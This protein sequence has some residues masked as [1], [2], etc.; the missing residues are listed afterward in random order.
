ML[1]KDEPSRNRNSANPGN[2]G[3]AAGNQ[4]DFPGLSTNPD[5]YPS[6][7]SDNYPALVSQRVATSLVTPSRHGATDISP[8]SA[9]WSPFGVKNEKGQEAVSST[10]SL[11]FSDTVTPGN[12]AYASGLSHYSQQVSPKAAIP[13][14]AA[15]SPNAA[16]SP[17]S[18]D[19]SGSGRDNRPEASDHFPTPSSQSEMEKMRKPVHPNFSMV[20]LKNPRAVSSADPS[21]LMQKL[22]NPAQPQQNPHFQPRPAQASPE[23]PSYLQHLPFNQQLLSQ[24]MVHHHQQHLH[25]QRHPLRHPEPQV[26]QFSQQSSMMFDP[27]RPSTSLIPNRSSMSTKPSGLNI[28][29]RDPP[30]HTAM[31]IMATQS[32]GPRGVV[33]QAHPSLPGAQAPQNSGGM[34]RITSAPNVSVGQ[35]GGATES[36]RINNIASQLMTNPGEL[37]AVFDKISRMFTKQ[38]SQIIKV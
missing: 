16:I 9:G 30:S 3:G 28:H 29:S 11:L 19:S 7:N 8:N 22:E 13:P 35:V 5:D 10:S 1:K 15:V 14:N 23:R 20:D 18:G 21:L 32:T 33:R 2:S 17:N 24:Q 12:N 34:S 27:M 6:L 36:S 31:Q 38:V 37:I 4:V 26:S 25:P